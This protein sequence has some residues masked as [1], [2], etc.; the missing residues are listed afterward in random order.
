MVTF[1]IM[2]ITP[3][4]AQKATIERLLSS[5]WSRNVVRVLYYALPKVSDISVMLHNTITG[6]PITDWMPIW[7]T[8]IF[9]VVV[10]ALGLWRF[11]RRTF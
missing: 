7:S 2:I 10:L 1:A 9:G 3:I 11:E 8:A 5:E 6:K 4:L